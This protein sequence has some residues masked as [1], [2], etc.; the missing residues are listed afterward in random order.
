MA[1]DAA[2]LVDGTAM[3]VNYGFDKVRF[4]NPV[5]S[6]A[7]IR[8]HFTLTALEE[9][10]GQVTSHHSVSVEIEGADKPALAAEWITRGYFA[11]NT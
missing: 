6:G 5:P 8:G 3:G 2:P 1:C 4:I 11:A 10:P 9:A 7:R